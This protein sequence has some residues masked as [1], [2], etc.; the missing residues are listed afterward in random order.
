MGNSDLKELETHIYKEILNWKYLTLKVRNRREKEGHSNLQSCFIHIGHSCTT[1]RKNTR[2]R[3]SDSI[4]T[5]VRPK[6][7]CCKIAE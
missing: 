3:Y 2:K 7:E 1:G 4:E 5:E 6:E